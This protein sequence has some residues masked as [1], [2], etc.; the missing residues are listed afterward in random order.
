MAA[1]KDSGVLFFEVDESVNKLTI[2]LLLYSKDI[3]ISHRE[4]SKYEGHCPLGLMKEVASG[5][6]TTEDYNVLLF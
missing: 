5:F 1:F 3:Y 4:H 2:S 6:I